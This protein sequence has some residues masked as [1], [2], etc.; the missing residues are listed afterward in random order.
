M[1]G[2]GKPARRW[3]FYKE[4][5]EWMDKALSRLAGDCRA[6]AALLLHETGHVIV[7]HG[8]A[9]E[10]AQAL[11]KLKTPGFHVCRLKEGF[12]LAV[13]AGSRPKTVAARVDAAAGKFNDFLEEIGARKG[14]SERFSHDFGGPS[15]PGSPRP[16]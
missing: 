6:R 13:G 8:I 5:F 1:E 14:E 9:V 10:E 15:W 11:L 7:S 12:L 3:V 16:A 4:D 2:M